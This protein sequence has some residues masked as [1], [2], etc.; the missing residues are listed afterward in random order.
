[1]ELNG[2]L[3]LFS[4]VSTSSDVEIVVGVY[5][6]T[7][8]DQAT[9][10]QKV[11]AFSDPTGIWYTPTSGLWGTVWS[12][13]VPFDAWLGDNVATYADPSSGAVTVE[14]EVKLSQ[15]EA[16]KQGLR[17]ASLDLSVRV[18]VTDPSDP[19]AALCSVSSLVII[20]GDITVVQ[21]QLPEGFN[22]WTPDAPNL[23]ATRITLLDSGAEVD[24]ADSYFG[25]VKVTL[26]NGLTAAGAVAA[27]PVVNGKPL[28]MMGTLDQGFWPD[29]NYAAPTDEALRF[30]LEAH[31]ALGFNTVRKHIKMEPRTWY[32]HC[33]ELGLF[34]WQVNRPV[35]RI[36]QSQLTVLGRII[37]LPRT[38][39]HMARAPH[40]P[41]SLLAVRRMK[42]GLVRWKEGSAPDV[43]TLLSC[44][45]K[46]T[47]RDGA[48]QWTKT[49]SR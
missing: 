20:G 18:D 47:M 12:E 2:R 49:G 29:G 27:V 23:Y 11:S 44:N 15:H 8:A 14:V 10:K 45:G 32:K 22:V 7:A 28:F 4:Q 43:V 46:P 9:G 31:K 39:P 19:E 17:G 26:E 41:P 6:A 30:D 33:D 36:F 13:Q 16:Q 48:N 38:C 42:P 34:V 35:T 3:R 40:R 25:A 24:S 1:M 37:L 21:F 5:D